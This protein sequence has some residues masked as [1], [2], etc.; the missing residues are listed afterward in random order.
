MN[1]LIEIEDGQRWNVRRQQPFDLPYIVYQKEMAYFVGCCRQSA[2]IIIFTI[3]IDFSLERPLRWHHDDAQIASFNR[4]SNYYFQSDF[5]CNFQMYCS[6][7]FNVWVLDI[8]FCFFD[9]INLFCAH[10]TQKII[11]KNRKKSIDLFWHG[12]Y[13]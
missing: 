8:F 13:L 7:C 11:E 4:R 6:I 9:P 5:F 12:I 2:I 1:T 3:S 10:H